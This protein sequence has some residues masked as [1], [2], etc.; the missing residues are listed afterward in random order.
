M[1]LI[2]CMAER[3]RDS[4][5]KSRIVFQATAEGGE[6]FALVLE[7]ELLSRIIASM[8][9][10]SACRHKR[11]RLSRMCFETD[12]FPTGMDLWAEAQPPHAV[13]YG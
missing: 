2:V 4:N 10:M 8:Q 3:V 9:S 13:T 1:F 6:R 5:S 7:F 11:R 12:N